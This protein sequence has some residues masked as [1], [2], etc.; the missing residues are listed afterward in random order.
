MNDHF[1][2]V[3]GYL[4]DLDFNILHENEEDG[5]FWVEKEDAGIHNL[6][7]GCLDPILVMEQ[8][9]FEIKGGEASD[10]YR[11]LLIKNRDIIHGA[12]VLDESGKKVIFRDTLQLENLDLNELEGSVNSLS[13]LL[14]EYSNELIEFSKS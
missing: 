9:L 6:V 1:E 2:K 12:F 11:K 5:V 10:I 3:Q 14:S 7:I 4:L 8:Y 13:L